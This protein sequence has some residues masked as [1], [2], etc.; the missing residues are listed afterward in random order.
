MYSRVPHVPGQSVSLVPI[1]IDDVNDRYLSWLHDSQ[2]TNN[3]ASPDTLSKTSIDQLKEYVRQ[4]LEVNNVWFWKIVQNS[5]LVH[6]GNVKLEPISPAYGYAIF[7]IMIGDRTAW[8]RGFGTEATRLSINAAF[9]IAE[10]NNI[11]LGVK[12]SNAAA[13]AVYKKMGFRETM[14]LP[15]HQLPESDALAMRLT[16]EDYRALASQN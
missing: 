6:I 9:S 4:R 5:S 10:I 7:G 3:L 1:T 12:K 13:I 16:R 2:V 15:S 14:C 11:Y 8:G